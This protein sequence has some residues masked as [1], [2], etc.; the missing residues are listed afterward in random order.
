MSL[1]GTDKKES[2]KTF[3]TMPPVQIPIRK[4]SG[5]PSKA[6]MMQWKDPTIGLFDGMG[7]NNP[8]KGYVLING[9]TFTFSLTDY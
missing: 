4:L 6:D 8:P 2:D 5:P 3:K 1:T 9:K 7:A